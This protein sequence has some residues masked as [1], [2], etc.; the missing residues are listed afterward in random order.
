M[1]PRAS[2]V[3]IDTVAM[4]GAHH[5]GVWNAI[6]KVYTFKS[7][8]YCAEEATR[9]NKYGQK[10]ISREMAELKEEIA[11]QKVSQAEIDQLEFM[12]GAH[13]AHKF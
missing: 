10:L 12:L 6:Y 9:A 3:F 13:A 7:A 2:V 5:T 4:V 1:V 11:C 8:D